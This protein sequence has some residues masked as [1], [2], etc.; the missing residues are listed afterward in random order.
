MCITVTTKLHSC[1][2]GVRGCAMVLVQAT[3]CYGEV[4]GS[5]V[6][7]AYLMVLTNSPSP[8]ADACWGGFVQHDDDGGFCTHAGSALSVSLRRYVSVIAR[9][10]CGFVL[11][12]RGPF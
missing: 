9:W 2:S 8:P 5:V 12:H 4:V 6:Q 10:C 7:L 11:N 3:R 1:I